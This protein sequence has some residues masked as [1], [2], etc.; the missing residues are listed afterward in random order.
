MGHSSSRRKFILNSAAI[1]GVSLLPHGIAGYPNLFAG[2]NKEASETSKS[3][4]GN[5]GNWAN[6]LAPKPAGLSF[7]NKQ[8]DNVIDWQKEA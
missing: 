7:L 1:G 6:K 8:W 4:I 5:Y 2:E 3:I